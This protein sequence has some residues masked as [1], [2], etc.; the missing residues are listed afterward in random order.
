MNIILGINTVF[1]LVVLFTT[2]LCI[3]GW[4]CMRALKFVARLLRPLSEDEQPASQRQQPTSASAPSQQP[5]QRK[6]A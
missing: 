2:T 6:A 4:L 3:L 5:Q 1:A